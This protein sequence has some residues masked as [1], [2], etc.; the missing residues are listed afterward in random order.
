ML[1]S[2]CLVQTQGCHLHNL[3]ERH[4]KVLRN[5]GLGEIRSDSVLFISMLGINSA[6]NQNN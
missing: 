3:D 1:C 6:T 4:T 5:L 2:E